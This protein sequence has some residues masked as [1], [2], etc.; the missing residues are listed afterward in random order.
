MYNW[1]WRIWSLDCFKPLLSR[2][3]SLFWYCLYNF[4]NFRILFNLHFNKNIFDYFVFFLGA[5]QAIINS[6]FSHWSSLGIR[7]EVLEV[8]LFQTRLICAFRAQNEIQFNWLQRF[9]NWIILLI[10][11]ERSLVLKFSW[12]K[13]FFLVFILVKIKLNSRLWFLLPSFYNVDC[14][15]NFFL[16]ARHRSLK[17]LNWQLFSLELNLLP[18]ISVWLKS[19]LFVNIGIILPLEFPLFSLFNLLLHVK[20]VS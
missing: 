2:L 11:L 1:S 8:F 10:S 13:N 15:L 3:F 19:A 20:T 12:S 14:L 6:W 4:R 7:K 18:L 9:W 5:L 17:L 16:D